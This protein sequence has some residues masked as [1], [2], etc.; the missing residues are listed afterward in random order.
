MAEPRLPPIWNRDWAKPGWLPAAMR[1]TRED[2]G[3][4][5][6]EPMPISMADSSTAP[7]LPACDRESKPIRVKPMPRGSEYGMGLRSV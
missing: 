1:A 2:S 6:D 4:K 5:T 7:K 3:W